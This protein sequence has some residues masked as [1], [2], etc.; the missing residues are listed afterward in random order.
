MVQR[1]KSQTKSTDSAWLDTT[2]DNWENIVGYLCVLIGLNQPKTSC[3]RSLLLAIMSFPLSISHFLSSDDSR[4]FQLVSHTPLF[5]A[6]VTLQ[7]VCSW[8]VLGDWQLVLLITYSY[9]YPWS[10]PPPN[11]YVILWPCT[12]RTPATS[13]APPLQQ[14]PPAWAAD[15]SQWELT[16]SDFWMWCRTP[17]LEASFSM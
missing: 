10:V 1:Q 2:R 6:C 3:F 13:T 14:L 11:L 16:N 15:C 12:L 5:P 17:S 7:A 8:W 4:L 9:R